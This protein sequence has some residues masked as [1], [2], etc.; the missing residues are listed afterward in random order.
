MKPCPPLSL[1][2]YIQSGGAFIEI[3][4]PIWQDKEH[5]NYVIFVFQHL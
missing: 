5:K 3:H 2:T 4:I 1:S